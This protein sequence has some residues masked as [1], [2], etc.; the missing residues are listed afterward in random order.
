MKISIIVFVW[1]MANILNDSINSII[2]NVGTDDYECILV[3]GN[4]NDD[5]QHIC[6]EYQKN[7][8]KFTY[9]KLPQY[10]ENKMWNLG[11]RYSTGEYVYFT[12]GCT[13]LC[14]NFI[15]NAIQ[16]L[17]NNTY[18]S[19]FIRNYKMYNSNDVTNFYHFFEESYIGPRLPMCVFRKKCIGDIEFS[20]VPIENIFSGKIIYTTKYYFEKDNTNSFIDTQQYTNKPVTGEGLIA[21]YLD[22]IEYTKSKILDYVKNKSKNET[23]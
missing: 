19:T 5:S 13:Y 17:D 11:L 4:S 22:W 7:N 3:D 18:I 2:E 15:N 8:K 6:L 20:D 1:N 21:Q 16:F 12:K 14:K 9:I 23:I 10:D